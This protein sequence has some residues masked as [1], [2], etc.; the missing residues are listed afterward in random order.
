MDGGEEA[1]ETLDGERVESAGSSC[2]VGGEEAGET[3]VGER[4]DGGD[5]SGEMSLQQPFASA[6]DERVLSSLPCTAGGAWQ[7]LRD[8]NR[9]VARDD[10]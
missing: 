6:G 8:G 7:S 3:V 1:G 2:V 4:D 9:A 5:G 10:S